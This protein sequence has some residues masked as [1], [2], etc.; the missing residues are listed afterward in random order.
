M[1][2]T[3]NL[4]YQGAVSAGKS[5]TAE[6]TP[7]GNEMLTESDRSELQSTFNPSAG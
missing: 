6:R 7:D 4:A 2:S 1:K 5:A 3:L